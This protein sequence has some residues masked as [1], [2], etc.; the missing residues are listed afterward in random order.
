MN[1]DGKNLRLGRIATVAAKKAL[2]GEEVN[3]FN[4]NEVVITGNKKHLLSEFKRKREM[5][6]HSTGP[7]QP[8]VSFRFVKRAIRGMLPYKKSKGR[9][10]FERIKCYSTIPNEFKDIKLESLKEAH[11]DNSLMSKYLTVKELCK[12]MGGKVE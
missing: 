10:A 9:D 2:L 4:C 6:T 5:G 1:I 3:I 11:I 12:S 8:R 7:F